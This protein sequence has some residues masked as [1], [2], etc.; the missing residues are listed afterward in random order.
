MSRFF[1]IEP[2]KRAKVNKLAAI[3]FV[4]AT[5]TETEALHNALRPLPAYKRRI[6]MTGGAQT[7]YIGRLG[8]YW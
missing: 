2:A 3:L 4:T 8:S 6:V 1:R 7:Y 5:P